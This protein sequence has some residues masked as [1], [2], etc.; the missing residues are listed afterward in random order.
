[1]RDSIGRLGFPKDRGLAKN[2]ITV[3]KRK[4]SGMTGITKISYHG[5]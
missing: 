5:K 4:M 2:G 3:N 1:M